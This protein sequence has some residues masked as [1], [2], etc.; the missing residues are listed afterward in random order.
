MDK[1]REQIVVGSDQSPGQRQLTFQSYQ[2]PS[3]SGTTASGRAQAQKRYEYID[4]QWV[5]LTAAGLPRKKPGRKPGSTVKPKTTDGADPSKVRKPRKPRDPSALPIQRKR[6]IAPASDADADSDVSRTASGQHGGI[7]SPSQ[8]HQ[9]LGASDLRGSPKMPKRE[10]YPG[11]M[12]SIL[13]ADPPSASIPVRSSGLSYDPIRGNYDPVRETITPHNANPYSST[14]GSPRGPAQAANRSP[15]IASIIEPQ[16]RTASATSPSMSQHGHP[17]VSAHSRLHGQDS[18]SMPPSPSYRPTSILGAPP[19]GVDSKKESTVAAI[20][21]PV[22]NQANFTTISN[23]PIRRSSPKLKPATGVS[24]PRTDTL[25]DFQDSEGRSILDFGKARPGEEVQAP[26]IVLTIPIGAGETNKYV[27]FMRLAEEQYGWDA[28]HP[29]QAANRDRK[30]RIEAATASLEKAELGRESGDEMSLDNSD[31]EASNP[32]NGGTSGPD[33]QVKPKKKR[34]FKEDQYDVEDDFVDDSELLWEAQAAASRDGFFV[35][36]GPLVP[37]VE[38]PAITHERPKRGR[39]SRGARGSRGSTRG[40]TGTGRGGGPG[41]RGGAVTR[42]PRI[43]KAERLQR[44]R[45]KAERESMAQIN[46]T[47]T[48]GYVLQPSTPAFSVSELGA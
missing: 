47:P 26:T 14:S 34:N 48:N 16:A 1:D 10:G 36:S 9:L 18:S 35:Y 44:E 2:Q 22:V 29:R 33:A 17:T 30:A 3:P 6:K 40:G 15:S 8:Q 32:E 11:S 39:G 4:G 7:S 25:D 38:K 5:Q 21:R 23:G 28:L 27:N 42:K 31:G 13:N 12:Q 41:S 37:E 45:E 46:K 24:T 43:T 19:T 20:Q